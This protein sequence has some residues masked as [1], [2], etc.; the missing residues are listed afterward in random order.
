MSRRSI[1]R[2]NPLPITDLTAATQ[3]QGN[4]QRGPTGR[5]N[6]AKHRN[7]S[8]RGGPRCEPALVSSSEVIDLT[9]SREASVEPWGG[10]APASATT[11]PLIPE[12]ARLNTATPQLSRSPLRDAF[13]ASLLTSTPTPLTPHDSSTHDS[14]TGTVE[15][16]DSGLLHD[17]M[18]RSLGV[19]VAAAPLRFLLEGG[20]VGEAVLCAI[21][22]VLAAEGVSRRSELSDS[23]DYEAQLS[24]TAASPNTLFRTLTVS[25]P[26]RLTS[27]S[28]EGGSSSLDAAD[29]G[30]SA[31][32]ARMNGLVREWLGA[33]PR[34]DATECRAE[35]TT[36]VSGLVE[37]VVGQGVQL[38]HRHLASIREGLSATL[39]FHLSQPVG[40]SLAAGCSSSQ[41]AED[42]EEEDLAHPWLLRAVALTHATF[43]EGATSG[44]YSPLQASRTGVPS[45]VLTP[46]DFFQMYVVRQQQ[47]Q[48]AR[49][50]T[51][52]IGNV[53]APML[54]S[55]VLPR[56]QR[57][58][59]EAGEAHPGI[60][61][62][63]IVRSLCDAGLLSR[64]DVDPG[65]F[66]D[67][68]QAWLW[69]VVQTCPSLSS[70]YASVAD[71]TASSDLGRAI[72]RVMSG[73]NTP[74]SYT[75]LRIRISPQPVPGPR[76]LSPE[77]CTVTGMLHQLSALLAPSASQYLSTLAAS[78]PLHISPSSAPT[79]VPQT[80]EVRR[81]TSLEAPTKD[82]LAACFSFNELRSGMECAMQ[83]SLVGGDLLAPSL[84]A[85][86]RKEAASLGL[87]AVAESLAAACRVG[88]YRDPTNKE[89]VPPLVSEEKARLQSGALVGAGAAMALACLTFEE[90][91]RWSCLTQHPTPPVFKQNALA[92]NHCVCVGELLRRFYSTSPVALVR[93][94]VTAPSGGIGRR[95][96]CSN[97]AAA[98]FLPSAATA[99]SGECALV[100]TAPL[101]TEVKNFMR[102]TLMDWFVDVGV[103]YNFSYDTVFIA[104]AIFDRFVAALLRAMTGQEE[105]EADDARRWSKL[106]N[107]PSISKGPDAVPKV[108]V[109][110]GLIR[111]YTARSNQ[112][113]YDLQLI[114]A[115]ALFIASKAE[116]IYPPTAAEISYITADAFSREQVLAMEQHILLTMGF[117]VS[118]PTLACFG[119]A[120]LAH[121]Q[122]QAAVTS[123]SPAVGCAEGSPT[124][125]TKTLLRPH[126]DTYER[127]LLACCMPSQACR[128][129]IDVVPPT[130]RS[131]ARPTI[132]PLAFDK[133]GRLGEAG[134]ITHLEH[135]LA[136][137]LA[138]LVMVYAP[139]G[140]GVPVS[141]AAAAIH[142]ISRL[143]AAEVFYDGGG[144]PHA[145]SLYDLFGAKASPKPASSPATPVR[146]LAYHQQS[147]GRRR[148]VREPSPSS[149]PTRERAL[150]MAEQMEAHGY[151]PPGSVTPPAGPSAILDACAI[152]LHFLMEERR[153][154]AEAVAVASE[155]FEACYCIEQVEASASVV[156]TSAGFIDAVLGDIVCAVDGSLASSNPAGMEA[157][158]V[159]VAQTR[160][161]SIQYL[162]AGPLEALG[163]GTAVRQMARNYGH[164]YEAMKRVKDNVMAVVTEEV[165]NRLHGS[166]VRL[167]VFNKYLSRRLDSVSVMPVPPCVLELQHVGSWAQ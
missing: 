107:T 159:A 56:L 5:H 111:R 167:A 10:F 104:S 108:P 52:T 85:L 160:E 1:S 98:P 81:H 134:S 95:I 99:Q 158:L 102:T 19:V 103:R 135:S 75:A 79:E 141:T 29:E 71:V 165:S 157:F 122:Q 164:T 113:P 83:S 65:P 126:N 3:A 127:S 57:L 142:H 50:A 68:A 155:V 97:Y 73:D 60:L 163:N 77:S 148:I 150:R 74:S 100:A 6:L 94:V 145:A 37:T 26:R 63:P 31:V 61:D 118:N 70:V 69:F 59:L 78:S 8:R 38:D 11:G 114:G 110:Q 13:T 67:P 153:H 121:R 54:R 152:V 86:L 125:E 146:S 84:E 140:C 136:S 116:E 138:H 106:F 18:L 14:S 109:P 24:S 119:Q 55:V 120:F 15:C 40:A 62:I 12:A 124:E 154:T 9:S 88:R 96:T 115:A 105:E 87:P 30:F 34:T 20:A 143:W 144:R 147:I 53:V 90:N 43:P 21:E 23:L 92:D 137:Y 133:A 41:L 89:N 80:W 42:E 132:Q 112:L 72:G 91:Q 48:L 76:I 162:L 117:D 166:S 66:S 128:G 64:H 45:P 51:A 32:E 58:L 39:D 131:R 28:A 149:S 35:F 22:L 2:S 93:S 47:Q 151:L 7:V 27:V 130:N 161:E 4:T 46:S 36:L 44:P 16:I 25:S 101:Q 123:S 129:L 49:F 139:Y 156:R 17:A 33:C 82:W